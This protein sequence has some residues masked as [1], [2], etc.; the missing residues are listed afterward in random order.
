[1]KVHFS[2][3]AAAEGFPTL[4]YLCDTCER[5]REQ[6]GKNLRSRTS[7]IYDNV[8]KVN[9][10]PDFIY[11]AVTHDLKLA[12]IRDLLITHTHND[13][14]HPGELVNRIEGF[15]HGIGH[16]IEIYGHDIAMPELRKALLA[17][18]EI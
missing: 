10:L 16:P 1:M 6:G 4:F 3:T 11:H 2:G 17:S 12:S 18:Q 8:L 7:V 9:F 5:A 15:A 14:I 13:H